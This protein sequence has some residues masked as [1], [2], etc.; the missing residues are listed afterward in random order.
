[1]PKICATCRKN[2]AV[3]RVATARAGHSIWKCQ[4]CIDRKSVSFIRLNQ[5][6]VNYANRR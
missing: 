3:K 5:E 6:K 1:M 4:T 2:P